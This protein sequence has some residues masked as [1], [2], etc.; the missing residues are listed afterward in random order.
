MQGSRR[1]G[2]AAR[3]NSPEKPPAPVFWQGAISKSSQVQ[4]HVHVTSANAT[5]REMSRLWPPQLDMQHRTSFDQVTALWNAHSPAA[6][7]W[8]WVRPDTAGCAGFNAFLEYL[9]ARQRAG[10]V[11]PTLSGGTAA[12]SHSLYLLPATAQLC[13]TLAV[14]L[15]ASALLMLVL[16]APPDA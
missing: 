12:G 14:P 13:E 15:E 9:T 5:C 10:I 6:R 1:R 16:A 2:R 4:S 3:R 8:C 11:K 7:G